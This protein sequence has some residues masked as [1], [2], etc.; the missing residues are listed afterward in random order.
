MQPQNDGLFDD[1]Y[2]FKVNSRWCQD[3]RDKEN[4]IIIKILCMLNL[5]LTFLLINNFVVKVDIWI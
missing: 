4:I 1:Q 2:L 5:Q 3:R